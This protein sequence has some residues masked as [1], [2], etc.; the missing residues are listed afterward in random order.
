[1]STS[2]VSWT[3]PSVGVTVTVAM[4]R[5]DHPDVTRVTQV[6]RK[7]LGG[8]ARDPDRPDVDADEE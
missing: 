6:A 4:H 5:W 1:M 8:E 2:S 7:P 3:Y